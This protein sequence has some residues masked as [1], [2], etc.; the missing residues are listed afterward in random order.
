MFTQDLPPVEEEFDLT[1]ILEQEVESLKTRESMLKEA[2]EA[3]KNAGGEQQKP[4][5]K[6][7]KKKKKKATMKDEL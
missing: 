5:K 4:K 2:E 3:L 7:K 6:K 1:E